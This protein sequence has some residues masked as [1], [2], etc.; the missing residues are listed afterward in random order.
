MFDYGFNCFFSEAFFFA[1]TCQMLKT[2]SLCRVRLKG[3][4]TVA[5]DW[6]GSELCGQGGRRRR[7]NINIGGL[8]RC[9]RGDVEEFTAA[10]KSN[11]L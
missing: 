10:M 5:I 6:E 1:F 2:T 4:R 8:R 3:Q 7:T 11:T 9:R